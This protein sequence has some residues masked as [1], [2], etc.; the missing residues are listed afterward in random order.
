[1]EN[2]TRVLHFRAKSVERIQRKYS[3]KWAFH[4]LIKFAEKYSF[5][6]PDAVQGFHSARTQVTSHSVVV[7]CT[8]SNDSGESATRS[9]LLWG[10]VSDGR[11]HN[12]LAAHKFLKWWL[13]PSTSATQRED[14]ALTI[15]QMANT[16][17]IKT[18]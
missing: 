4:Y 10:E 5:V 17:I 18:I 6:C 2:V 13:T 12:T 7:D 11:D 1:V 14:H 15:F 9:K 8:A 16:R 3:T